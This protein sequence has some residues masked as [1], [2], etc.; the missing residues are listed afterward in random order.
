MVLT[1]S[2]IR[3][4]N[5]H[6]YECINLNFLKNIWDIIKIYLF[7]ILVHFVS[8]NLYCYLCTNLS[9]MGF[10]ISPF[11]V[12]SPH[13]KALMWLTTNSITNINNMWLVF[14]TWL[15]TKLKKE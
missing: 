15:I 14:A 13:C 11:I 7:W 3:N 10:L 6:L 12:M 8:S 4:I 9:I 5:M 1:R 2:M